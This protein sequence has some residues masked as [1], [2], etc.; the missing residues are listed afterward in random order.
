MAR[1]GSPKKSGY[2]PGL[3]GWRALAVLGVMFTHDY[4]YHLGS[5]NLY[6]LQ[7]YGGTGVYLFFAISGIL[8]CTRLLEEEA[9]LGRVNLKRFYV[10]RIFRIQPVSWLYLL[11]VAFLVLIG[12]MDQRWHYWFGALFMYRNY[13]VNVFSPT[14]NYGYLTGHFWTLAVEEHF[15]LLLS[16]FLFFIRRWRI[17]LLT[18]FMAASVCWPFFATHYVAQV[19]AKSEGRYTEFQLHWLIFPALIAILYRLPALRAFAH[20]WMKPWAV[21]L[22][23]GIVCYLNPH[24]FHRLWKW[25]LWP[26][27]SYE[28]IVVFLFLFPFCVI[29]TISHPRSL[30]TRFLELPLMQWMG[31]LSYSLYLWHVLFFRGVWRPEIPQVNSPLLHLTHAPW[32]YLA[33]FACATASFYFVERPLM[34]LGHRLA[35][36]ATPGRKDMATEPSAG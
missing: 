32:N 5:I 25:H 26:Q 34:R 13:Q 11:A 17:A 24:I 14:L 19:Y 12:W 31:R 10:R 16:L 28:G 30:T 27:R 7:Q 9:L 4:A 29:A 22:V 2:L 33:A 18:L 6:R 20:R 36:P 8:I 3:D 23:I 21:F 15:Y 35:P 1:I